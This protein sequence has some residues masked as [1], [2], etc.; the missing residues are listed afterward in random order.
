[1]VHAT[2]DIVTDLEQ[3]KKTRVTIERLCGVYF[4]FQGDELKYI[5]Q[6]I[7]VLN[8]VTEH[9][10]IYGYDSYAWLPCPEAELLAVESIYIRKFQPPDNSRPCNNLV[11]DWE[12][13]ERLKDLWDKGE[14]FH[15]Q[16]RLI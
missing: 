7:N 15:G 6:S 9:K 1:M 12:A 13:I 16:L 8:R 10:R 11:D 3:I 4:C 2:G 14:H 5:G